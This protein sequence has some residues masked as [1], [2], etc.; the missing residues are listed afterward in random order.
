MTIHF[1]HIKGTRQGVLPLLLTHGWP[2]SFLRYAKL[3]PLLSE[4]DLVVLS[5]PGF[6][7]STLPSKGFTNNAEVA[8]TWHKLMTQVLGYKAYAAS[9]GD[10]VVADGKIPRL[11]RLGAA[12][13]GR[14]MRLRDALLDDQYG[15]HL[16]PGLPRQFLYFADAGGD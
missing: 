9:G 11:E 13:Y 6:A 4:F 10:G 3:F 2:D 1:F 14:F 15:L 5:L 7:F 8:E 16:H 12:D